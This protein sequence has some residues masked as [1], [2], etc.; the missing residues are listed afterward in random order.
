MMIQSI[1]ETPP[2]AII[3]QMWHRDKGGEGGHGTRELRAKAAMDTKHSLSFFSAVPAAPAPCW[4]VLAMSHC[5]PV[6]WTSN[7]HSSAL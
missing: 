6:L 4:W 5:G 3:W 2:H 7:E 1:F